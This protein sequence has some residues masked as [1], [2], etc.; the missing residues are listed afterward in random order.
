MPALTVPPP[1]GPY[2][3]ELWGTPR[4]HLCGACDEKLFLGHL[5]NTR[6]GL[7]VV[8]DWS[9]RR[10]SFLP[11]TGDSSPLRTRAGHRSSGQT[12]HQ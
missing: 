6:Q 4:Y 7:G 5:K 1:G 8:I 10:F 9:Q 2:A 12:Y 3:G 11:V